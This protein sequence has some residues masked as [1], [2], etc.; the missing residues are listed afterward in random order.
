MDLWNMYIV[1]YTHNKKWNIVQSES[2]RRTEEQNVKL[3]LKHSSLPT[4]FFYQRSKYFT[5]LD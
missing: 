5:V 2:Q 1:V 4:S 3:E